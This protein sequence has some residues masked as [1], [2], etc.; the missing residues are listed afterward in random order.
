VVKVRRLAAIEAIPEAVGRAAEMG[1]P[2]SYA[3]GYAY[4]S[5]STSQGPQTLASISIFGYVARLAARYDV[6]VIYNTCIADSIPLVEETL[7]TAYLA[8]GKPEKYDPRSIR[9]Q[10]SQSPMVSAVLGSFQRER[11]AAFFM[12]GGLYY[13][14]VVLGEGAN[15]IGA[16]TIGGTAN[17]HQMPFIVATCDY[18]LLSEELFAASAEVSGDP[19]ALGSL[20]GEDVFKAIILALVI[21][22]L[23]LEPLLVKTVSQLLSW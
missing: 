8:E 20:E 11:P 15:T 19:T 4:E 2:I 18:V 5:L 1:R 3:P 6:P 22:G 17:T 9:Y 16:M 23:I 12:I 13:E 7:R 10:Y 14:S 21:L